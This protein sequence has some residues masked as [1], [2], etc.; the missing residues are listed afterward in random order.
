LPAEAKLRIVLDTNIIV[1]AAG[2]PQSI[3]AQIVHACEDRRMVLLVSKRILSEYLAVLSDA[4]V[5]GRHPAITAA[6]VQN[7]LKRLRYVADYFRHVPARFRFPRDPRDEPFI[8]LAITGRATHIISNDAD[9]LSLPLGRTDAAK[10]YR[11]RLPVTRVMHPG[12][13][14]AEFTDLLAP[15]AG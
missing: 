15:P 8:E 10:R 6:T 13:F 4:E 3:A 1:R 14:A 2:N 5:T 7:L 12:E 9:L 11:Q